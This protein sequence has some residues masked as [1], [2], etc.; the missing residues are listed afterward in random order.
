MDSSLFVPASKLQLVAKR[1]YNGR[2]MGTLR[3]HTPF[4]NTR[5]FLYRNVNSPSASVAS[6]LCCCVIRGFLFGPQEILS[7]GKWAVKEPKSQ[8]RILPPV[9]LLKDLNIN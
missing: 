9:P 8:G 3:T 6:N 7:Q 4:H 1:L 5:P 2:P